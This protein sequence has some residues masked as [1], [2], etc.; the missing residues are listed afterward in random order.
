MPQVPP[1]HAELL[2]RGGSRLVAAV[3]EGRPVDRKGHYLHWNEMRRRT[4]PGGL[5]HETWW[6]GT[7]IARQAIARDLPLRDAGG[8]PFRFSNVDRVQELVHRIDRE[9]S[10][11]ILAGGEAA[12]GPRDRYRYVVSSLIWEAI[13]SSRLEGA[14]TTRRGRCCRAAARRATA[15]SA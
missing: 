14:S 1:S 5:D 8:R 15:A 11:R 7:K 9:A 6:L 4:P 2:Q 3:S 13:T 10:G 12:I